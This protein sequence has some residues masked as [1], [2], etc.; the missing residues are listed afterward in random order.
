M[1]IFFTLFTHMVIMLCYHVLFYCCFLLGFVVALGTAQNIFLNFN[2][3]FVFLQKFNLKI[4]I[5]NAWNLDLHWVKRAVTHF[6]K[7]FSHL[8][9]HFRVNSKKQKKCLE[10]TV[11]KLRSQIR[12]SKSRFSVCCAKF[13]FDLLR[14]K[15]M[16]K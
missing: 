11:V 5:G 13:I 7:K 8:F 16:Q 10:K 6:V 9:Q 2:F 14:Q 3:T 1:S 4:Q 12:H 15:K